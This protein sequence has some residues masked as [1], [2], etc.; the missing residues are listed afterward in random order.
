MLLIAHAGH[1]AIYVLYAVP[2]FIVLGSIARTMIRERRGSERDEES[3]GGA[4]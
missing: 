4:D 3:G 2:V 1:W